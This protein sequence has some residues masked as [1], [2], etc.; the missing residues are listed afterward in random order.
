[1]HA[2]PSPAEIPLTVFGRALTRG[3]LAHAYALCGP[4]AP[5]RE[6]AAFAMARILL[7]ETPDLAARPPASCGKC[8][9][10]TRAAHRTHP[11][12]LFIE[13]DGA[14]I[15][16]AQVRELR[17]SLVYSPLEAPR[18]VIVIREAHLMNPDAANTLLKT[19]EEPGEGNVFLLTAPS[20]DSLLSTIASRCQTIRCPAPKEEAMEEGREEVRVLVL[21]LIESPHPRGIAM[22]LAAANR[23]SRTP[24][25]AGTAI[26]A[27][28][29]LVRDI[30]L[31]AWEDRPVSQPPH[32]DRTGAE[33][34]DP[35]P[36]AGA[37][38]LRAWLDRVRMEDL[39]A[40]GGWL[41]EAE[42]TLERNINRE[43][44]LGAAFLPWITGR[45]PTD[46]RA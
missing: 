3:R 38:S 45:P 31:S 23:F 19:L 13:P 15:R 27:L 26:R 40:Y 6:E 29:G 33:V 32:P 8:R 14:M 22:V 10:C 20:T 2:P 7:C 28:K 46:L 35:S 43:I 39:A 42:R 4:D 36:C 11:D 1:M 34:S 16:V 21:E 9:G 30:L 25:T 12:L 37:E 24:E 18:R 17:R 5:A 44:L 41:E